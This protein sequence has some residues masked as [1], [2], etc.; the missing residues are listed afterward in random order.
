MRGDACTS[1][2]GAKTRGVRAV[3]GAE[4]RGRLGICGQVHVKLQEYRFTHNTDVIDSCSTWLNVRM[5]AGLSGFQ[6]RIQTLGGLLHT[7]AE[8]C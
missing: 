8:A 5:G 7:R 4:S 2:G 6:A 3:G 1:G